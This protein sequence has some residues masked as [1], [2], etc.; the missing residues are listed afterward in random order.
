MEILFAILLILV[1]GALNVACFFIGAKVGQKVDKGEPIE[2]PKIDP[3]KPLR[4]HRERKEAEREREHYE[5]I[6]RN[7]DNYNGT[8]EGQEDLPRG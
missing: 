1:I 6:L 4:E 3:L 8:S 7:I 2:L 5:A